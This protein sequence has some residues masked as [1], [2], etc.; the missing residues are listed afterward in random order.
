MQT[1]RR[2]TKRLNPLVITPAAKVRVLLWWSCFVLYAAT[3]ALDILAADN[4]EFQLAAA[5]WGILHPPGYPLYTVLGALWVRLVPFGT[6]PFRLNLMSAVLAATT[7]VL[8]A[9]SV[10]A[11]AKRLGC[12]PRA[13]YVGGLVAVLALAAAP[14]FWAQ[15]TTANIRMP[16]LLFTAWGFLALAQFTQVDPAQQERALLS[17]G[18]ALGLGAGHHPSLAFVASGW[19]L[20]ILVT[21]PRLILHPRR[22]YK[23]AIA[24]AIA[25]ALPQLYLPL[26]GSMADVPLAPSGLN[27]WSGFWHHVLARGFSGDMFAFANPHDLALRLPLLPMLFK[28]QFPPWILIGTFISWVWLMIRRPKLGS[29]LFISWGVHTFVTL[30]YRAPQ[31]VEYLM[32]AY[33]PV[34]LTLGLGFSA[35]V[36]FLRAVTS[37]HVIWRRIARAVPLLVLMMLL[38]RLPIRVPN[39]LILAKDTSVRSRTA[40]LLEAV[41]FADSDSAPPLLLADWRWATPLWVLQQVEGQRP[42]VDVAYVYPVADQDYEQVWL[43]RAE[44]AAHRPILTTHRYAWEGWTFAPVGGGYRLFRRPLTELP[45]SLGMTSLTHDL[46]PVRLVGYRIEGEPKPGRRIILRVAWQATG[47]Q[48][49]AP[50]FTARL[51][52]P[53]GELVAQDDRFLGNDT[54]VREIRFATFTLL[55]PLGHCTETLNPVVGAYTLEEGGFK[56]LGSASLPP[57]AMKCDFP[58]LPTTHPTAGWVTGGGPF[59]R[60]VDY[61]VNG[62]LATAYLHWCGPGRALRITSGEAQAGVLPLRVGQCQTVQVPVPVGQKPTFNLQRLDGTP[63]TLLT[64]LLPKPRSGQRYIPFG[65]EL[66]LIS[67][68]YVWRARQQV[69]DLRWRSMRPLVD[70]YA[71]SVRLLAEDG[72]W[73]GM[74]DFQPALSDVPTLKW[75]V[76]GL[77]VLDPHPFSPLEISPAHVSVTVYER[78]RLTPLPSTYGFVTT[79][80]V[81][82]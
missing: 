53:V 74:H 51:W 58:R 18:M 64:V 66:L 43:A 10:G 46:G 57:L 11:W 77:T 5:R 26:R 4:G 36:R 14:T 24:L 21:D 60:G 63:V 54:E 15:A 6:L 19:G 35:L 33:I 82:E 68:R 49:P 40:P 45:A 22:W 7:L 47:A 65:N 28:L 17:L 71:V 8:V 59:L 12:R 31:T 34:V 61:D 72:M 20:Y 75:V 9:E 50:S 23:A 25:W 38:I 30:T 67:N 56:D 80:P 78:F 52:T 79:F 55:V 29:L 27:T 48:D 76:R 39:F 70:D 13:A 41:P 42:D 2:L 16:T 32:P 62:D 73:L 3:T 1:L 37:S 81:G 69:V 44:A